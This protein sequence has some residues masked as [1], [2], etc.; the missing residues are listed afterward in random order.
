MIRVSVEEFRQ[1]VEAAFYNGWAMTGDMVTE[2]SVEHLAAHYTVK[3]IE[4]VGNED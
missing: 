1:I 4:G 3:V 2:E